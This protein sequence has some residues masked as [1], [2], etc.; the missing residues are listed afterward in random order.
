MRCPE[1]SR[2]RQQ[3]RTARTISADPQLTYAL[4]AINVLIFVAQVASGAGGFDATSG[5]VFRDGAL[6]GPAVAAG[7]WWRIIT[8]GFL[9]AGFLHIAFNMYFVY[10]LG[11]LLE[12]A[13]GKLRFGALYMVSLLGGSLGALL[14]DFNSPTVGAS[15]AAFGLLVAGILLMRSRGID[16][17]QSGLVMTLVLNLAITFLLPGI[18]IGGHVGGIVAGGLAALLLFEVGER[19]RGMRTAALAATVLLG[20]VIAAV[21]IIYSRNKVG[22]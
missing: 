12:P 14:L 3:V 5:T 7:D 13:I 6:W 1:C 19:Q 2:Q 4:I 16:P 18:S 8:G 17:M 11:T 9:H 21:C 20:V 22:I 15:G 10:F